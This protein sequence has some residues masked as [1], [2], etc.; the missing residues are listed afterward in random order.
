VINLNNKTTGTVFTEEDL[1]LLSTFA[2]QAAIAVDRANIFAYRGEKINELTVL[3]DITRE[4]STADRPELIGSI[5]FENIRKLIGLEAI[6][7]Y[8]YS[9]RAKLFR[10]EF[11]N[12]SE[13][14]PPDLVPPSELEINKEVIGKLDDDDIN[15]VK[16]KLLKWFANKFLD[17]E[18]A[19]AIIPVKLHGTAS[20]LMVIISEKELDSAAGNL[21]TVVAS[22]AASVYERQKAVNSGMQLVTMGKMISE[23]CHDLKKPLTNIKGNVQVYKNKI[24]GKEAAEYFSSSE[25]EL[26]RLHDLVMEI[27]DFA[28]P[29]KYSTTKENLEAIIIKAVKLLERDIDKKNIKFSI[30]SDVDTPLVPVNKNEIFQTAINI[31]LNAIESMD[32]GGSLDVNIGLHPA[33]EPFVRLAIRDTGSG[34]PEEE[35]ARIFDRYYTTKETGTGLG[36][37]IVERVV[38]AHNGRLKVESKLGEGTTFIIDLPV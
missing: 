36:L 29:S 5:I 3:F 35:L 27:V 32:E 18:F 2:A 9:D 12:K 31:M 19:T 25:K 15:Y 21:A 37:A 16:S 28:N 10:L 20:S 33:G 13:K 22:Q 4:I 14:C 1:K 34:I 26:S 38:D 11:F 17:K 30:S 7:W 8:S 24:K 23:I 6:I